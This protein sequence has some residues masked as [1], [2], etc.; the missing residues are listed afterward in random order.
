MFSYNFLV[1]CLLIKTNYL[2]QIMFLFK[3]LNK[4]YHLLP[5]SVVSET[6]IGRVFCTI[7]KILGC[8]NPGFLSSKVVKRY[9]LLDQDVLD[10]K[11]CNELYNFNIRR[12]YY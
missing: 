9:L 7:F 12:P 8:L 4:C 1:I 10:G 5:S 2:E 3:M 6:L 11:G